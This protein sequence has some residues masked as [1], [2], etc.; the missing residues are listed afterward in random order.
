MISDSRTPHFY[1]TWYRNR[2]VNIAF[3]TRLEFYSDDSI[4]PT[5]KILGV[6]PA[7]PCERRD[8]RAGP[9]RLWPTDGNDTIAKWFVLS[10]SDCEKR[11]VKIFA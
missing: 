7:M 1:S 6:E 9:C 10:F 3:K 2:V 8:E 11:T 4:R 5:Y